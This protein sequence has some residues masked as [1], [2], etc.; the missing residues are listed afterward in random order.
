M[1]MIWFCNSTNKYNHP[2]SLSSYLLV[3][4][5]ELLISSASISMKPWL[6]KLWTL[7]KKVNKAERHRLTKEARLLEKIPYRR[8]SRGPVLN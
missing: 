8:K 2:P 4:W 3:L 7:N 1:H 6:K 5:N